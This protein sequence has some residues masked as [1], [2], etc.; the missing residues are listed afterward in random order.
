MSFW[1]N[2][3]TL[4]PVYKNMA[5]QTLTETVNIMLTPQFY[6]LKKV[7]LPVKYAFQ[8]KKVAA[9]MFDG[10]LENSQ[11]Y[12]YLV[13]KE[14]DDWVFIAYDLKEISH[15]L[16]SKGISSDKVAK[17]FFA[18]QALSSFSAP[19]RLGSKDALASMDDT[20]VLV[21]QSALAENS[22]TVLMDEG[23]T[24]KNGISL[25]GAFS[26]FISQK[27]ALGIA[28]LFMLFAL[29]FFVEGWR[30]SQSSQ[31][32]KAEITALIEEYPTLQSAYTRQSIAAKYRNIDKSEK[33]KRDM[34]KTLAG[35]IFKGV[36]VD[37][38]KMNEKGFAVRFKCTDAKVAK[39]LRELAKKEGFP[40]VKTLTGNIVSIEE[41]L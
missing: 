14:N 24:P 39:H 17:V 4:L 6:I 22:K 9:S 15:F 34:V 18:Q 35:M 25:H 36:T 3:K 29:A 41:K 12:D 16:S 21:P 19:V 37:T 20:V 23:F 30:Y 40:S 31:N 33:K 5:Q 10:L 2:S 1:E 26:S 8:A 13:Y 32:T 7:T 38:F 28:A 11:N 27:Q